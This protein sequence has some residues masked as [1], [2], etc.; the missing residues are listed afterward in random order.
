VAA[1]TEGE[2]QD[3]VEE[4]EEEGQQEEE[5]EEAIEVGDRVLARFLGGGKLY[6]AKVVRQRWSGEYA[7]TY[8]YLVRD[9]EQGDRQ[10]QRTERVHRR[11]V[12]RRFLGEEPTPGAVVKVRGIQSYDLRYDDGEEE[13]AVPRSRIEA[14]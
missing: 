2:E 6:R 13:S 9:A 4:E 1:G 7:I 11:Q 10:R 12:L 14:I 8:T 3:D 5:E